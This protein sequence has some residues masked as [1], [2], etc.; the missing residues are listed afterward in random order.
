MTYWVRYKYNDGTIYSYK[1]GL[2]QI[3]AIIDNLESQ[4]IA[5]VCVSKYKKDLPD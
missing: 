2:D 4:G 3:N 1:T 5:F